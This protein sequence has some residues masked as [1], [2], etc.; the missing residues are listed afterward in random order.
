ML[1]PNQNTSPFQAP[2][3]KSKGLVPIYAI[4]VP[5]LFRHFEWPPCFFFRQFISKDRNTR[6]EF[7]AQR[8]EFDEGLK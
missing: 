4:T 5:V 1:A 2:T 3:L 6:Q 8:M 7:A